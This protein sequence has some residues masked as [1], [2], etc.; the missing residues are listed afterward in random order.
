MWQNLDQTGALLL[1]AIALIVVIG[2]AITA[3]LKGEF[4]ATGDQ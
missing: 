4:S 3:I 1:G 2:C